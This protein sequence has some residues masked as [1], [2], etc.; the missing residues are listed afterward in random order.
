MTPT[1]SFEQNP[2]PRDLLALSKA[3]MGELL[4]ALEDEET[5]ADEG[6]VVSPMALQVARLIAA[7]AVRLIRLGTRAE[8]ADASLEIAET[9]T[10]PKA[11]ALADHRDAHRL[12]SGASVTLGAATP[13]SSKGGE[14]AVLRSWNGN[15]RKAVEYLNSLPDQ[16]VRRAD[17][18]ELLDVDESYLSHLLADL[19][20]AGL[21]VRTRRGRSVTVHLG[22]NAR[23]DHVQELLPADPPPPPQTA[24]A[25]KQLVRD[26]FEAALDYWLAHGRDGDVDE[27]IE[28]WPQLRWQIAEI[29]RELH[30]LDATVE[31][32]L[33]DDNLV[34]CRIRVSGTRGRGP[35]G[36]REDRQLVWTARIEDGSI[37]SVEPWTAPE[38]ARAPSQPEPEPDAIRGEMVERDAASVYYTYFRDELDF[39]GEVL[40]QLAGHIVPEI[41]HREAG[42]DLPTSPPSISR[43]GTFAKEPLPEHLGSM[44]HLDTPER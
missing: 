2:P 33:A 16:A 15:A 30:D 6:G 19:E 43:P 31:E 29:Q 13:P 25:R 44:L 18:R 26:A 38:P 40:G 41:Q 34:V 42:S 32:A 37:A 20:A 10:G 12:V 8:L 24:R 22:P 3:S 39:T 17:L 35:R 21:I 5:L 4:A 1:D 28:T 27:D 14:M 11:K 23:T 7:E 36:K 9:L